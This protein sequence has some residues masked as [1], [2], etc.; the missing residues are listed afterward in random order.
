VS[1]FDAGQLRAADRG[2]NVSLRVF[3]V[4]GR[5][6]RTVANGHQKAGSYS[7][8]WDPKDS[9]GRQVARGVYLYRLDTPGF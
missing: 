5:T 7:V 3:D 9:R 8:N 1:L 2:G 4:T 6:V